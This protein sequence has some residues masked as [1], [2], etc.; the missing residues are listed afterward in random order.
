[1]AEQVIEAL[2]DGGNAS[3][4]P[5]LGPALGPLGVDIK[6]VID[7]INEKTKDFKGMKVPV[8]VKVNPESKEFKIE[9]G[10]P[11]TSQLIKKELN[12]EK[13]AQKPGEEH[14]ADMKIEQIIKIA[15]MKKDSIYGNTMIDV[16]KTIVGTC[17][18]IGVL[19]EGKNPKE[20]IAE[21]NNGEYKE[22]ILSG[23]TELSA[24]ELA[25]Q[26]EEKKKMAE[27]LEKKHA[28]EREKAQK[29]MSE[30]AGEEPS[31]IKHKLAEEGISATLI[32]NLLKEV[33]GAKP[34]EEEKEA[35]AP[36]EEKGEEKNE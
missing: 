11:S 24:E 10:S 26:E 18:S 30:M 7:A 25:K 36:E 19:V 34:A 22:K 9:V 5:P 31:K 12:L 29:I 3:S 20:I 21:I 2:V 4:G 1:M 6:S 8:K 35:E 33:A 16:V 28:E 13:L 15:K 14:V 23:K 27:E 32:D 17:L